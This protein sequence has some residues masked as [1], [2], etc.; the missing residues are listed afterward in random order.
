MSSLH[1]ESTEENEAFHFFQC[2]S[3]SE[4]AGFF[5]SRFWQFEIPQASHFLPGIR[6]AVI[7]LASMHRK[8]IAGRAPVVPDDV[9]D[10]QLRFAL[11][12]TNRAI[13]EIVKSPG[14]KTIVDK[15]N[16][17]TT[18]VLFHCLACI[19]G[20]Q[21]M[22][23][24]HLRGG[25]KML[26]EVDEAIENG[27]EDPNGHPVS[28]DNLRAMLVNMDVQARGI[29]CNEMLELWEPQP[30]RNVA[31][32]N[33]PLRTFVQAR[34]CFESTFNE[35]ITFVQELD[36]RPPS[37]EEGVQALFQEYK[38]IQQQFDAG[39]RRLDEFLSQLSSPLSE[40]DKN[41]VIGIRLIHDQ[42][43]I[44]LRVFKEFDNEAGI[45]EIDWAIEDEDMEVI[46]DLACQLLK[47]P[48][49]ITLPPGA[50]PED[51]YT[52]STDTSQLSGTHIPMFSSPVFS[53]CSGLLSALWV[54]TSR[55]RNPVLRR[56]TIA[57][58]MSYPRR[59]GV[60]D[61]IMA[62][63]IAWEQ[64]RFEEEALENAFRADAGQPAIIEQKGPIK[65]DWNRVRDIVIK[66]P[67]LR[68]AEVEFRSVQQFARGERG[69]VRQMAW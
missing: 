54:V 68:A 32:H 38:R 28:L 61:S 9:S 16:M 27:T 44:F 13:Q 56:K 26:R 31:V 22:A 29:M 11:Q 41:S 21:T 69:V 60:W 19:Q 14:Q 49:D 35:L 30:K 1:L 51:Y 58:F 6:H 66:Y 67:R 5:D 8:L 57:L 55:S 42:V 40:A 15:L 17:M 24:E 7:A 59:E 20:H 63:R 53:S 46:L 34:F 23:F 12:Q 62:G 10:K 64:M 43:N 45:G 52:S 37:T 39:S 2:R 48:A 18:C 33:T 36:V 3:A 4:L 50:V 47:A 65:L 25:L